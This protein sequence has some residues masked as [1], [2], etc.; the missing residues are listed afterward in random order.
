MMGLLDYCRDR[1]AHFAPKRRYE[2]ERD[3]LIGDARYIILDTELTGLDVQNDSI[4]SIGALRMFGGRIDMGGSFYRMVRPETAMR[5]ESVVIH[6]IT[7]SDVCEKPQIEDIL[8]DLIGFCRDDIIVGHF[9]HLDLD[10]INKEVRR[11]YETSLKNHVVDTRSIHSWLQEH[12]DEY[13]NR[14]RNLSEEQNLFAI[15]KKYR[16]PVDGA[17]NALTDAFI[18]AQLFQ[19]FLS[20]LPDMGVRT[21]RDLL[22]IGKP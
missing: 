22:R 21:L 3:S 13:R 8:A 19:R 17:H 18:T 5:P 1:I 14:F 6:E 11:V 9:I 15:A 2:I 7:P 16:I 12:D 10:F 4:V 20:I